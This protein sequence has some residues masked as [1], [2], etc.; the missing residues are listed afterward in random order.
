MKR[1][2]VWLTLG[3]IACLGCGGRPPAEPETEAQ[4]AAR[5]FAAAQNLENDRKKK[6]PLAAY[7]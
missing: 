1:A 5:V 2:S 4:G 3:L 6:Q 7:R